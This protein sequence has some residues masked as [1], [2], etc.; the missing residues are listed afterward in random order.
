MWEF[1]K[2]KISLIIFSAF[3]AFMIYF[4]IFQLQSKFEIWIVVCLRFLE[5]YKFWWPGEG[6]NL[7]GSELWIS[8]I[9][10]IGV[11]LCLRRLSN[12]NLQKRFA[13]QTLF[14]VAGICDTEEISSMTPSKRFQEKNLKNNIKDALNWKSKGF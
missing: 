2:N 11:T 13:L 6:L 10:C 12:C 1:D 7:R 4:E 14:V 8:Y 5:N 3:S 9:Q